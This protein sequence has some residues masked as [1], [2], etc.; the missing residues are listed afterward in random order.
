[1]SITRS[2]LPSSAADVASAAADAVARVSGSL[3]WG[4]DTASIDSPST[5][6]PTC[7]RVVAG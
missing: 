5:H 1:M 3:A 2:Q 6:R 7:P 4:P